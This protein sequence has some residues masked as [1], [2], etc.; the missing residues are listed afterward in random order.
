MVESNEAPYP[1][2]MSFKVRDSIAPPVTGR[3]LVIEMIKMKVNPGKHPNQFS[4]FPTKQ[5]IKVIPISS[6]KI[7]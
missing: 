6:P 5:S 3:Y 7:L 2:Q 1:K 4:N